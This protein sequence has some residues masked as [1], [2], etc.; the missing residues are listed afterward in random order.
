M[1]VHRFV[2]SVV[3]CIDGRDCSTGVG[4]NHREMVYTTTTTTTTDPGQYACSNGIGNW[5]NWFRF[6]DPAI[7]G[8][9]IQ[10]IDVTLLGM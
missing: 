7:K 8:D 5:T 9:L 2:V 3:V 4:S 10:R 1:T 6:V